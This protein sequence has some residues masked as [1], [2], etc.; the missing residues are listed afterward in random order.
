M[1][2]I[3]V[4]S[5]EFLCWNRF[6]GITANIS[7]LRNVGHLG[8]LSLHQGQSLFEEQTSLIPLSTPCFLRCF[9]TKSRIGGIAFSK[10]LD[11]H[12]TSEINPLKIS[13]YEE[14]NGFY[15][16]RAGNSTCFGF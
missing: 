4:F 8:A 16:C 3:Y 14:A 11:S 10:L 7:Q 9:I 13:E 5:V 6:S 1:Q 15:H 2:R 12:Y